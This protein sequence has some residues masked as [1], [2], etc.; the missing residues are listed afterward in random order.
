[1]N[2][3]RS[4]AHALVVHESMFGN[5]ERIALAVAQGLRAGGAEVDVVAVTDA[6]DTLPAD[7]DLIVVGAP[8]H[9][10]S[11]SRAATRQDAVRQGASPDRAVTGLREWLTDLTCAGPPP[12]VAIFDT[13]AS[14]VRRLPLAAGPVAAR[15]ARRR[16]F[17]LATA[18]VAFVVRD[19][20]GPLLDGE[21]E[22]AVAWGARLAG[23]A[24]LRQAETA[25]RGH[26]R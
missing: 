7:V 21:T 18:P 14:K 2:D 4:T 15:L 12:T 16:G 19:T 5:T 11:L 3:T 23:L 1:M 13:R 8:T 9:A 22:D 24:H 20:Q 26:S 6:P 17:R 10:F 25:D